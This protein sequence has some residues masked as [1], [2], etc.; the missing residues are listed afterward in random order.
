LRKLDID[1]EHKKIQK[2]DVDTETIK[3]SQTH[4]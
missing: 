4:T 1:K 2:L 3:N